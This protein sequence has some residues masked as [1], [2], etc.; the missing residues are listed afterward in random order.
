MLFPRIT[1]IWRC[2]PIPDNVLAEV[3]IV[4]HESRP[5]S[6]GHRSLFPLQSLP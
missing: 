1:D 5:Q 3:I 2:L 4:R 6:R